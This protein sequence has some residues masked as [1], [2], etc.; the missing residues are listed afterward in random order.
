[1]VAH[2]SILFKKQIVLGEHMFRDCPETLN[3][4]HSLIQNLSKDYRPLYQ[5]EAGIMYYCM[6]Y[7]LLSEAFI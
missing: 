1:M 7:F 4:E 3:M 5:V 2:K 6:I